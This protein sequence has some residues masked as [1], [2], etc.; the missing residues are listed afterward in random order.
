M[1][2][3]PSKRELLDSFPRSRQMPKTWSTC[4]AGPNKP[5]SRRATLLS[6]S[7]ASCTKG[8][9]FGHRSS[10]RSHH[11]SSSKP[12]VS[13]RNGIKM[14]NL[15]KWP[16]LFFR[17]WAVPRRQGPVG[18]AR[19]PI[20]ARPATCSSPVILFVQLPTNRPQ[21]DQLRQ[22]V[23]GWGASPSG[24]VSFDCQPSRQRRED[25]LNS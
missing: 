4:A 10:H 17:C 6:C 14:T 9:K 12:R 3:I 24:Q 19:R 2:L 16:S 11:L 7:S 25:S 22:G 13:F 1:K 15:L 5:C 21:L 20:F 8:D 18:R 23:A